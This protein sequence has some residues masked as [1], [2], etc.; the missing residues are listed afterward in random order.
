MCQP[1]RGLF[2]PVPK[3]L[4]FLG[5]LGYKITV[6]TKI[7]Q[8]QMS[9]G[10]GSKSNRF[11]LKPKQGKGDKPARDPGNLGEGVWSEFSSTSHP[12]K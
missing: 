8:K 1:A 12:L 11:N 7:G 5:N 3:S 9:K 6:K 4:D 10:V 2:P